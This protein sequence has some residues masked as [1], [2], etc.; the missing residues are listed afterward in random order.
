MQKDLLVKRKEEANSDFMDNQR[1]RES[2]EE[3]KAEGGRCSFGASAH[4]LF[5]PMQ[6]EM[7]GD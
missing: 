2:G 5:E 1:H 4:Q 3:V 6:G 7:F